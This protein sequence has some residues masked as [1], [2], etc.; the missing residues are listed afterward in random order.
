MTELQE[1]HRKR[2]QKGVSLSEVRQLR[3][4]MKKRLEGEKKSFK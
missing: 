2:N 4:Y 3:G 1:K